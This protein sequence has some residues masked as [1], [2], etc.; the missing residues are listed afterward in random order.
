MVLLPSERNLG[1][2]LDLGIREV[3][4]SC[5]DRFPAV[6]DPEGPRIRRWAVLCLL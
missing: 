2:L 3:R 1:E 5:P 6:Q 4:D